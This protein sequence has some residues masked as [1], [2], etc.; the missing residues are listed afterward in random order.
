MED[1]IG[2]SG[3]GILKSITDFMAG[4]PRH[5]HA[6]FASKGKAVIDNVLTLKI[7]GDIPEILAI[8]PY[9]RLRMLPL[10]YGRLEAWRRSL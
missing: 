6:P 8:M 7:F 4:R 3:F 10:L 2:K 9:Y 1:Q 5:E